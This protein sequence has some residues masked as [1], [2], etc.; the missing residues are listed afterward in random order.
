VVVNLYPWVILLHVV[1]A[2]MFAASHGV[3]IWMA[4]QIS[5][6]RD[7]ARMGALLDLSSLSLGGVYTGLVLLLIGGIWG[8]IIGNWFDK[9]WIW[10]ALVLLIAITV[11]MYLVATPYFRTLR[12]ALGIKSQYGPK[13]A[14]DPVALPDSEVVALAQRSPVA[15]LSAVGVGG[16]L[17]ILWL[18][19]VKPF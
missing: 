16:L 6:E 1:G 2:F 8:G 17:L 11:V 12:G 9:V 14:P 13:D 18:M 10:A 7:R 3:A 19:V 4:I 5:R 15:I